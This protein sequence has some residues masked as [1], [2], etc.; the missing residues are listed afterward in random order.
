MSTV[1]SQ[2]EVSKTPAFAVVNWYN[3][4]KELNAG[5]NMYF[6]SFEEARKYAYKKAVAMINT[7]E[8]LLNKIL[9]ADGPTSEW[10]KELVNEVSPDEYIIMESEITDNNGRVSPY[11][12]I[13]GYGNSSN[14]Y[15]TTFFS[16]VKSFAGVENSWDDWEFD[17]EESDDESGTIGS[18]KKWVPKY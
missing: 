10:S 8:Y 4:R 11:N 15:S 2:V 17:A 13:I 14:G 5:F 12:S 16:V 1:V 7:N 3:Y 9:K 18:D 6:E